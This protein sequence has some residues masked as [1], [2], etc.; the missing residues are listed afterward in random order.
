M[1]EINDFPFS[2]FHIIY[3]VEDDAANK[4]E[5]LKRT[6]GLVEKYWLIVFFVI[7][8]IILLFLDYNRMFG[9]GPSS[10]DIFKIKFGLNNFK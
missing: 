4:N 10:V 2:A 8:Q 5:L 9:H 3:M 7:K 1:H 6:K